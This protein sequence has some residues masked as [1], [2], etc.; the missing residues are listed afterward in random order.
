MKK[1]GLLWVFLLTV[2]MGSSQETDSLNQKDLTLTASITLDQVSNVHGGIQTGTTLLALFDMS[3]TYKPPTGFLKNTS[4]HL[5]L[6]KTAGSGASE[7]FI[8]DVQVAS[9]IEGRYTIF[10]YELLISQKIGHTTISAGMHDLNSEFMMSEYAGDFI[11]S[12]FGIMPSVSL[13]VPVS[14]FPATTFGG[15]IN[16]SREKY[17][18]LAGI[19]NLNYE[20][21]NQETFD[22]NNHFYQKGFLA[23]GEVHYRWWNANRLLVEFRVG[24]YLKNCSE[25]QPQDNPEITQGHMNYGLYFIGDVTAYE[26][27][28]GDQLG[29]FVQ[30]GLAPEK[31]NLASQYVGAGI[32]FRSKPKPFRP[33][34]MGLAIGRV[35]LNEFQDNRYVHTHLSE[36]VIEATATIPLFRL[37]KLQP[38]IQYIMSP[39]GIYNNALVALVRIQ[40][41][42]M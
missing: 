6:L 36:T 31:T 2:W 18:V 30:M 42:L 34:Q 33:E 11:N 3:A 9:N 10:V 40:L 28:S 29:V 25:P 7:N 32:S 1:T 15:L 4:F 22:F 26:G 17:D 24:G 38:D 37:I 13:N 12:S 20:F 41:E 21:C 27:P 8:G 39:S 16:Y 19:Y 14:I 5:H 35:R 23:V